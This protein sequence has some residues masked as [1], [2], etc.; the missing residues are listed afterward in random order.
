MSVKEHSVLVEV[1]YESNIT[2]EAVLL[3]PS[4]SL[5]WAPGAA[6]KKGG[7]GTSTGAQRT[8]QHMAKAAE[9]TVPSRHT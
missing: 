3:R 4:R 8:L 5:S 9:I 2:G 1:L 7:D 6:L